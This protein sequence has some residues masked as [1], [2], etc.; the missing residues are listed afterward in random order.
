MLRRVN[1]LLAF[2]CAA[3]IAG[4]ATGACAAVDGVSEEEIVF[5]Q[6]CALDG[7]AS[8][9]GRDMR[10]GLL[11]AFGE[12]NAAG[13]VQGRRLVLKSLDDGY[14]PDLA[15]KNTRQLIEEEEVFALAGYVG[16]PTARQSLPLIFK[17][18]IPLIGPFT[19]AGFLRRH[20][21]TNI[22]NLRAS[23]AQETES[24]INYLTT[25]LGLKRIAILFQDDS[26]G[27]S[28]LAGVRAALEK[29]QLRLAARGTYARN[30]TAVHSALFTIRRAHPE[31]V[32]MVGA[33]RPCAEF[34]R[35]A[36]SLDFK[37]RFVNISFVGAQALADQ[38][39]ELG[40]G[41]IVSQVVPSPWDGKLP[42][43]KSYQEAMARM[44]SKPVYGFVSLEGY[45]TGRLIAVALEQVEGELTRSSFLEAF[46]RT[47]Q[48]ELDG[49]YFDIAPGDNQ[50]SDMVYLTRLDSKGVFHQIKQQL[51]SRDGKKIDD[52]VET[53]EAKDEGN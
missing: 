53:E 26:F 42:V 33:Y 13:G 16:T 34:I 3:A 37:P 28:G 21:Y 20:T 44:Q 1:R 8:A 17:T 22:I 5:G 29:R 15:L 31:A 10:A 43:V 48:I 39:Q 4:F 35:L 52:V 25:D 50:L 24:W 23:Y 7:P 2:G 38:L 47:G 32:V 9:I 27:R 12:V 40:D 18:G 14:E 46:Y 41:V 36:H 51:V 19:G 11:A 45:L 49:M 6:S 30:L